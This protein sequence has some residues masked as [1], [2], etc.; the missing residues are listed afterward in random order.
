[1]EWKGDV[2][3]GGGRG[4]AC[5]CFG[6]RDEIGKETEVGYGARDFGIDRVPAIVCRQ[7]LR[8]SPA[9]HHGHGSVLLE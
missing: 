6:L 4:E 1:M 2:V 9:G 7:P 5:L 8:H 3:W